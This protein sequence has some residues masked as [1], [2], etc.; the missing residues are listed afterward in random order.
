MS[1]REALLSS[2]PPLVK[3]LCSMRTYFPEPSAPPAEHL[4]AWR[5]A[6]QD[7]NL[8]AIGD[9]GKVEFE[10]KEQTAPQLCTEKKQLAI[11]K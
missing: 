10:Q 4:A 6:V 11:C 8:Y 9:L 1:S 3:A 2:S 5:R 7:G